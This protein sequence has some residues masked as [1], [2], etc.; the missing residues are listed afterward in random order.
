MFA[1]H[2]LGWYLIALNFECEQLAT[3]EDDGVSL[4]F[5]DGAEQ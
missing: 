5:L 4:G 2:R 1:R 3:R